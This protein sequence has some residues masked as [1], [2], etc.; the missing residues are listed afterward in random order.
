M[1]CIIK[2]HSIQTS[3]TPFIKDNRVYLPIIYAALAMGIAP[4]NILIDKDWNT[5]TFLKGNKVVQFKANSDITLL[6]GAAI[7]LD[8]APIIIGGHPMLPKQKMAQAYGITVTWDASTQRVIFGYTDM[9]ENNLLVE[10]AYQDFPQKPEI[11]FTIVQES[12]FNQWK[13]LSN[14]EKKGYLYA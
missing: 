2:G 5:F 6:N 8:V 1:K 7:S 9:S 4:E 14:E 11:Y 10:I 3:I 13:Q 12:Y